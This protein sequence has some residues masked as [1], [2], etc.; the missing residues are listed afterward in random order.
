V[1]LIGVAACVLFSAPHDEPATVIVI[2][3]AL[4]TQLAGTA[5]FRVVVDPFETADE[6]D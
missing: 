3:F 2:G 1:A 5:V 6:T 4:V